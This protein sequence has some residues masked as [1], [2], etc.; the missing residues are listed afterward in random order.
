M[1]ATP[2]V[3]GARPPDLGEHTEAILRDELGLD[4]A[5]IAAL[6]VEEAI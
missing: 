5:A 1:S 4:E 2:P 6:R 3:P